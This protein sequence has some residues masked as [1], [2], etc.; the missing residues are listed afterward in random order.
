[1]ACHAERVRL[2]FTLARTSAAATL[3]AALLVAVWMWPVAARGV[4]LL[5]LA[6]VL[7]NVATLVWMQRHYRAQ[8]PRLE[9]APRWERRF[10][11]KAAAGG[12]LWGMSV[13]LLAPQAGEFARLFIALTLCMVCLGATAVFSPS[14]RVYYAFIV[15][16][17]LATAAFLFVRGVDGIAAAGWALLIYIAVLAGVHDAL[18]RNLATMLLDRYESEALSAEHKVILDSAAEA[19]GLLRPNY[20]AKCNRQWC[21]LA[22]R[23]QSS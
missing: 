4:L 16:L 3:A 20:L 7:C 23:L 9:E 18:Y 19:I 13:W 14:R 2:L 1:M 21:S 17:A 11:I 12:L 6:L 22:K 15:P 5:W 8:R 10:A